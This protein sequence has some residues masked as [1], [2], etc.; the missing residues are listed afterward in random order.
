V[1]G[2]QRL[3]IEGYRRLA[4]VDNGEAFRYM[5]DLYRSRNG[6]QQAAR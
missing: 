6:P 3:V 1:R 4:D 5:V 2:I